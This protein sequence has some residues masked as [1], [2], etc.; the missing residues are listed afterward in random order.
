M[1]L[2]IIL[3]TLKKCIKYIN[4][5]LFNIVDIIFAVLIPFTLFPYLFNGGETIPIPITPGTTINRRPDTPL[6][7]GNPISVIHFEVSLYSP[8]ILI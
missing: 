1:V 4:N 3:Y 7:A 8:F 2:Y 6:F 5:Y